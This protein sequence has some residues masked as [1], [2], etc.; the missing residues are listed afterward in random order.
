MFGPLIE[1][2]ECQ[3]LYNTLNELI[4]YAKIS[5][6]FYLYLLGELIN[7]PTIKFLVNFSIKKFS[8]DC[9]SR[10]DYNESHILSA[11]SVKTVKDKI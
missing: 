11:K 2:I 9:R 6:Q 3:S 10:S 8:I 1:F 4:D 7:I 5:D